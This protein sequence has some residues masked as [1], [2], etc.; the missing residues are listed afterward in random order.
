MGDGIV[1][2][3]APAAD[4]YLVV[5]FGA[6]GDGRDAQVAVGDVERPWVYGGRLRHS[7]ARSAA[8]AARAATTAIPP[9]TRLSPSRPDCVLASSNLGAPME[10][11][12]FP[13]IMVVSWD[14]HPL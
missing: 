1:A 13:G 11:R 3:E 5:A 7:D 12:R 2:G 6:P 14:N 4:G 10:K 9:K 8:L